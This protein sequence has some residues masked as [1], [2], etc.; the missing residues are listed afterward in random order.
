MVIYGFGN[1]AGAPVLGWVNDKLGGDRMVAK[2]N[3]W[4]HLFIY[5]C[6]LLCNEIH[7]YN[8]FCYVSAFIMGTSDN[9]LLTQISITVVKYFPDLSAQFYALFNIVKMIFMSLI[10]LFGGLMHLSQVSFRWFFLCVGLA[11]VL[12]QALLLL[13]FRFEVDKKEYNLL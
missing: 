7:T 1:L 4:L 9:A 3:M 5:S 13:T 8:I 11:N 10:L 12:G 2:V 6:M